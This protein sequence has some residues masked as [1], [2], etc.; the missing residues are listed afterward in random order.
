MEQFDALEVIARTRGKVEMDDVPTGDKLFPLWGWLTAFF[1]LAEFV[2]WMLFRQEWCLWLWIGIPLTGI[3]LMIS[4]IRKGHERTHMRTRR[5]KLVLD[6]WIFAACAIGIGGFLFGFAGIYELAENPM[7]CLLLGIGA[8]I[9]GEE[10]RFR[11]MIIGGIIG[12]AA[13]IGAFLLQGEL[14]TWQTLCVV[15][16]AVSALIVP[17]H[18]YFK[19]GV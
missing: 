10:C 14:W 19:N 18:I 8:F 13:G 5:S 6:Y 2:L 4:M 9:T 1:Y 17:G 11:P 3:P 15:F 12:A 7:I 16:T